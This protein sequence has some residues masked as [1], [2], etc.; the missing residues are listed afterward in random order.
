MIGVCEYPNCREVATATIVIER[1]DIE[2]ERHLCDRHTERAQEIT[3]QEGG[4]A[5]RVYWT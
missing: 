4:F 2:I 3:K 5:Y 1:G